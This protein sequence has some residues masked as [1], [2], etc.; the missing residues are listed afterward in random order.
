MWAGDTFS[1]CIQI[2]QLQLA[3]LSATL[4]LP[5][6]CIFTV[7]QLLYSGQYKTW[8]LDWT[9]DWTLDSIMD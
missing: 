3:Q 7:T 2:P 9:V 5:A 4:A 1:R 8:T 6:P